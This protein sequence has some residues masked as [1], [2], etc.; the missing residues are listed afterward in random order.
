MGYPYNVELQNIKPSFQDLDAVQLKR[1]YSLIFSA[2]NTFFSK[3]FALNYR[4]V[5]M[6]RV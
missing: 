6:G 3:P 2:T 5:R 4:A 1:R